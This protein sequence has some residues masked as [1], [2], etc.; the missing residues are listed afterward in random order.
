[1]NRKNRIF[2]AL[3]LLVALAFSACNSSDD[4]SYD[5]DQQNL[6]GVAVKGFSLQNNAKVLNNL[7]SVFFSIDLNNARI[8]NA[9][10]LPYGTDVSAL[11]VTVTAD[12]CQSLTIYS[13]DEDGELTEINYIDDDDA[14]IDFSRGE[15]KMTIVS[16]DGEHSRDYFIKVNVNTVVPDS[17][18]WSDMACKSL[19]GS[20]RHPV[21]QKT[22]QVDDN[23]FC[24]TSDGTAYNL[25]RSGNPFDWQWADASVSFPK[26]VNL[27][28]FTANKTAFYILATDGELLE[29]ADGSTWAGTG[30][31][32]R[33]IVAPWDDV[34]ILGL[35]SSGAG[36]A[37]VTYPVTT[38][39][40]A[41]ADFPVEGNSASVKF[42]SKWSTL[43][44]IVTMGGKKSDG[45]MTGATWAYDG[46]SWAK[47]AESLPAAEGYAV[48]RYPICETDTM[49]WRLKVSEVML[50]FGG[51]NG[52]GVAGRD[53]Y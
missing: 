4:V 21:G 50:A 11:A 39:T 32:W 38:E 28:S 35:K 2:S 46:S 40:V 23:I 24:L 19:P 14:K 30:E 36:L 29:S 13:P 7:D 53:V 15:V 52:A 22:V 41:A 6:S 49:S 17:L 48:T 37:H 10:P 20:F 3:T 8:F 34:T 42:S 18:F 51:R 1:M 9:S 5:V 33:S 31:Y 27:R 47:I 45:S 26:P 16:Y 25:S 12:E 44:Q 43:P